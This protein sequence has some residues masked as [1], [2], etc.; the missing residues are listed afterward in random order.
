LDELVTRVIE[1]PT[2]NVGRESYKK[3]HEKS[4]RVIFYLV[5]ESMMPLISHLRTTKEF[6]DALENLYEK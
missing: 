3:R 1:E 5:K 6:F 2:S 4:K